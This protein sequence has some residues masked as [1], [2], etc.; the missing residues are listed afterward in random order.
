M[1]L[2]SPSSENCWDITK[3]H[4]E[5]KEVVLQVVTK[6]KQWIEWDGKTSF[7]PLRMIVHGR[8]GTGKSVVIKTLYS[9]SYSIFGLIAYPLINASNG[10]SAYNANEKKHRQCNNNKSQNNATLY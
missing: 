8:P 5:Q 7:V 6:L 4:A 9:I 3:L 1:I 10:G 2:D